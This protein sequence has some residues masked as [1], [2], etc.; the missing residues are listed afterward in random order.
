MLSLTTTPVEA[1]KLALITVSFCVEKKAH[2]PARGLESLIKNQLYQC[3]FWYSCDCGKFYFY[4]I[5]LRVY[6]G[7]GKWGLHILS[8]IYTN[9]PWGSFL[10]FFK[11]IELYHPPGRIIRIGSNISA[12]HLKPL[13]DDSLLNLQLCCSLPV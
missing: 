8:Q 11:V 7:I 9:F 1:A 5:L 3:L 6:T 4:Y 2:F 13:K 10:T 12:R